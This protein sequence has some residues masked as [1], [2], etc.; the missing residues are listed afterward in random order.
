MAEKR[1][2]GWV[3]EAYTISNLKKVVRIF[4]L[5]SAVNKKL[6]E[7]KI[8][9]LISDEYHK[10]DMLKLLSVKNMEIPYKLLKGK[11]IVPR[12]TAPCTGIIQAALPGQ[13]KNIRVIG[14]LILFSGGL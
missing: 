11:G 9:R 10:D 2:F 1:T 5:D 13:R 12:N 4:V 8:P 3:Q 7:D 6:R 14:L